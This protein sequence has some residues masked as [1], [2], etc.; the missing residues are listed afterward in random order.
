MTEQS[1]AFCGMMA[2]LVFVTNKYC[3][4]SSWILELAP[5]V[6]QDGPQAGVQ[7]LVR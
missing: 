6:L 4:A 7:I 1:Q 2:I 3:T 5:R